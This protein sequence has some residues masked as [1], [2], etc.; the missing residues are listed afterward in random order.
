[1]RK[2]INVC[3]ATIPQRRVNAIEAIESLRAN[4]TW[5]WL[6]VN[7]IDEVKYF[8]SMYRGCNVSPVISDNERYGDAK[9]YSLINAM[10]GVV[11]TCVS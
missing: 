8:M 10:R 2:D 11:M 9:R 5:I 6:F 7:N 1:M 4:V 3:M